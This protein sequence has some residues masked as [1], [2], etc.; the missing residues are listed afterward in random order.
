MK[1]R[2]KDILTGDI[3]EIEKNSFN[4]YGDNQIG[5][6]YISPDGKK[7]YLK[8]INEKTLNRLEKI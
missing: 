4:K 6:R 1:E 5:I 8:I 3:F 7:G 2:L